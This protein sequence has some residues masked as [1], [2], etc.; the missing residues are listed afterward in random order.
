[1][2]TRFFT[3]RF[4][5]DGRELNWT[6]AY[7]AD[8]SD[9]ENHSRAYAAARAEY[10]GARVLALRFKE[11]FATFKG[12][13]CGLNFTKPEWEALPLVGV[14]K[15]EDPDIAPLELRNC[16]VCGTTLSVEVP[17]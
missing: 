5:V 16:S 7:V 13:T 12:C 17:R 15:F 14:Q 2:I 4:T 3:M 9:E 8:I 1:M 6:R 11:V 10:P